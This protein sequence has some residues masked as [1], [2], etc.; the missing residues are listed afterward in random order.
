VACKGCNEAGGACQFDA[1]CCPSEK[2][3]S[4]GVC[5][6]GTCLTKV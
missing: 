3:G 5:V 2:D 6:K 4:P 1:D